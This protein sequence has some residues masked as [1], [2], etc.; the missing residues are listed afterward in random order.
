MNQQ[1]ATLPTFGET[2]PGEGG[3][4]GAIMRGALV[5]KVR[6]PDYAIIV[7]DLSA[8]LMVWG[9]YGKAIAGANSLTDGL[10]N[11]HAM[12]Q[13]KCPPALHIATLATTD[14]HKDLYLPARAE[15]W[16]LRANVP[17]LFDK[18]WHWT[19]TQHSSSNAFVQVF[20]DGYSIWS[21]K[22]LT[23]R[24]RPVR[25]IPLQHFTA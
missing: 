6:Q 11:T 15:Y 3:R 7:P 25:R 1:R 4:L 20:E 24:V 22:D 16:A 21:G 2:V 10:A 9:E 13:A 8:E 17:E 12:L 5:G 18:T 14:G 19:S 23:Y